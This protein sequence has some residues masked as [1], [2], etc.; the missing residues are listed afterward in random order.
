MND[1]TRKVAI[2]TAGAFGIGR[3]L[4]EELARTDTIIIVA[5]INIEGAEKVVA[6][7][8][9]GRVLNSE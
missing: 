3:A 8:I 2:I 9:W 5:D 4:C 1:S 6:S 7:K